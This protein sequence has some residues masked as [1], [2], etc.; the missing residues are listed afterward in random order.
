MSRAEKFIKDYTRNCSNI[1]ETINKDKNVAVVYQPWLTPED[2]LRAVEIA[3]EEVVENADMIH[4]LHVAYHGKVK[5]SSF[6]C[7]GDV[8]IAVEKCTIS[9]LRNA[10]ME[11]CKNQGIELECIPTIT[12][13]SELTPELFKMLMGDEEI[14]ILK[15]D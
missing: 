5:Y 14:G 11:M 15:I 7:D 3:R 6:T 4:Y 10:L 2:A 8:L 12:S 9:Q 1:I 13:I